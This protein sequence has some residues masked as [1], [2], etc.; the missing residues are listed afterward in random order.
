MII[1]TWYSCNQSIIENWDRIRHRKWK[2]LPMEKSTHWVCDSSIFWTYLLVPI[3]S[4]RY[5]RKP[6]SW[7]PWALGF[8]NEICS[9]SPWLTTWSKILSIKRQTSSTKYSSCLTTV[10]LKNQKTVVVQVNSFSLQFPRDF[11]KIACTIIDV[12]FRR[13]ITKSHP[14]NYKITSCDRFICSIIL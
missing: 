6:S 12:I 5:S 10:N 13:I 9:T 14:G 11:S 4:S 2:L 3:I 1:W 8:I 7:G